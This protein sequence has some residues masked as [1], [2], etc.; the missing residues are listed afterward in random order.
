MIRNLAPP[1]LQVL[2]GRFDRPG[3]AQRLGGAKH[4]GEEQ[5]Y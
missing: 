2:Q 3:P 4:V 1:E 5:P